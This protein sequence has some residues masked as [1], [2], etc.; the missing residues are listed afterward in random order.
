MPT[1]LRQLLQK[2]RAK[3]A[4]EREKGAYF[5]QLTKVW[6]EQPN[7][8]SRQ[9]DYLDGLLVVPFDAAPI[10]KRAPR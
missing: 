3:A 8:S 4:S 9:S 7:N 2:Y 10:T 1:N 6:L 5:E